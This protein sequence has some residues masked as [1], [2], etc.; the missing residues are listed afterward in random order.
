MR[1]VTATGVSVS[2]GGRAVLESVDVRLEAGSWLGVIGPNGSGKSTLL[3]ALAGLV[4]LSGGAVSIGEAGLSGSQRKAWARLVA[5]VAQRPL[6]PPEM[7]VADYVLLG[8]TPH[9]GALAIEGPVDLAVVANCLAQFDLTGMTE[10][11]LGTLSGGEVQRAILARAIAQETP[12]L[13]LDEP[14]T[15]LDLGH[16]QQVLELVEDLRREKALTVISALHDL[17][18]AAQFCDQLLLLNNGRVVSEGSPVEVL[19]EEA[20]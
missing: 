18:L 12:V 14:T 20:I 11:T 10:R 15:A 2:L 7:M 1:A 6:I 4:P 13:L 17:T 9:L 8:R 3:H 19:T 5:V 16:Q